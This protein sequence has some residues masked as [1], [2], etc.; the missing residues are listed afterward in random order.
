MPCYKPMVGVYDPIEKKI[1]ILSGR[2][3]VVR[4][5]PTEVSI[6]CG[7][8]IGCR[9]DRSRQWADRMMME[10]DH[11]KTAVFLTLTYSPENVPLGMITENDIPIYSLDKRDTQLFLKRLR[12][13]FQDRDIRFYCAGEY[14]DKTARPHYHMIVFGLSLSDFSDARLLFNNELGDPVYISSL[15]SERLWKLGQCT[16]ANVSWRTCAYVA[17]YCL[18]KQTGQNAI[19]YAEHN[20]EPEFATMSRRPGLA[21]FFWVDHPDA[22]DDYFHFLGDVHR[23]K[24]TTPKYLLKKGIDLFG[25]EWYSSI[26]KARKRFADDRQLLELQRTDLGLADYLEVKESSQ[27]R[28]LSRLKKNKI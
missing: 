25:E 13:H 5:D 21:G 2:S 18:K 19:F 10:L 20:I 4:T 22:C 16:L 26:V 7:Q 11:S 14:G 3:S 24:C 27:N 28:S 9:L 8:C 1:K 23:G 15:L 6:P 12:F 17:R